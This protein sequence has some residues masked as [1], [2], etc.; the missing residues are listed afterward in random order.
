MKQLVVRTIQGKCKRCYT[1]IRNC[2]AKA[3]RVV[4]GQAEVVAERCVA[5]GTCVRICAQKAKT[6]ESQVPLVESFLKDADTTT[7]ACLAPSY[8]AA[9]TESTPEHVAG[10]LKALGFSRVVEVAFGAEMVA[11]E[12]ERE[13][14]RHPEQTFISTP[15]PVVVGLVE[16]YFTEV[17]PFLAPIV[18]PMVAIGRYVKNRQPEFLEAGKKSLRT[19]FIGPCIAKKL[20]MADEPVAGAIDAVVTFAELTGMFKTR[21]ID[22]GK[23]APTALDGPEADVGRSFPLS[24]GLLKTTGRNVDL[25]DKDIL[26]IDGKES[27]LEILREKVE[28]R[29]RGKC[30]DILFCEGCIDGPMMNSVKPLALRKDFVIRHIEGRR[31]PGATR[32]ALERAAGD[33]MQR[34]FTDH[35]Q[36]TPTPSEEAIREILLRVNKRTV[37]DEF[38]C[39]ACGYETCREKAK[40]VYQGL[41]EAEMCLPYLVSQMEKVQTDLQTSLAKLATSYS[42]LS[43][44][45][46]QLAGAHRAIEAAQEQL[47]QSE[48]MAAMGQLA[49]SVAHEINNP[50]TGILTYT[51]L[52]RSMLSELVAQLGGAQQ[53]AQ[54]EIVQQAGTVD[55]K[56]NKFLGLMERE[57][58]H[59]SSTVRHLLDF[60]KQSEPRLQAVDMAAP[61]ESALALLEYQMVLQNIK[62]KKEY[63]AVPAVMADFT[64]LRQVFVNL[65]LNACQA[66][67]AGGQLT[68]STRTS[69]DGKCVLAEVTDTGAGISQENLY[70]VFVPF[71]TTKKKGTGLGL[72]VAY[73]II[74][75]H[76]GTVEVV[77]EEGKGT[78]FTIRMPRASTSFRKDCP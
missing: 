17:I 34:T 13:M 28:G 49:A 69:A 16:K 39:G 22:A 30:L 43:T 18:S 3:I 12:Y 2:P 10:A 31:N 29:V 75:R 65:I 62:V 44:A 25:L 32:I 52:M 24:S 61:I 38:N 72:S 54:P 23:V 57:I 71:F 48:K 37:E 36:E 41:A 45:H 58:S 46:E 6:S 26:V 42:E 40:A 15:C 76:R 19:V 67:T 4:S 68:L 60:A 64:Q 21:G 66:M 50:M 56:F 5:C 11:A 77:S 7:V 73:G 51:R 47:V 70:K 63:E 14:R 1:C 9:L 55:G 74:S 27:V 78:T 53:P 33:D 8:V 35:R 20:E 59:C